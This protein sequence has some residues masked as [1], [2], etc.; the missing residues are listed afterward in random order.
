MQPCFG[1]I[2]VALN[3]AQNFVIDDIFIAQL[4]NRPAFDIECVLL[5]ALVGGRDQPLRTITASP[6]VYFQL[7]DPVVVFSAESLHDVRR[8][9]AIDFRKVSQRCFIRFQ[10]RGSFLHVCES[11]IHHSK[12]ANQHW[13]T[14]A[15]STSVA[16][17]TEKV[18]NKM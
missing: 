16:R 18:M 14:Q 5:Q 6:G 7:P 8:E 9:L 1:M 11:I 10:P 12:L 17:I 4:N 15:W 13:Q 3:A 2:N